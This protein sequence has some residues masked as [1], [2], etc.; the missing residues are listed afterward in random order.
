VLL[1]AAC[2]N[3]ARVR[4]NILRLVE[5]LRRAL[6]RAGFLAPE[7]LR[8]EVTPS[9]DHHLELTIKRE[10]A[11]Y[12]APTLNV[13]RSLGASASADPSKK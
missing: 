8:H 9:G 6:W 10:E 7:R 2:P 3:V 5:S 1:S 12:Q 13:A 11:D 4:V